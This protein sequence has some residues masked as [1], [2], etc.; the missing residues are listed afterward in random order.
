ME[1]DKT[2]ASAANLHVSFGDFMA[3]KD[4]SFSLQQGK[5]LAIVE[6]VVW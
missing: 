2:I 6:K 3:V 1:P 5:T 4:L